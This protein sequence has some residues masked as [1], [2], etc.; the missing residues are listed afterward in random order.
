LTPYLFT[1]LYGLNHGVFGYRR[2]HTELQMEDGLKIN[3]KKVY[4]LYRDLGLCSIIRKKKRKNVNQ[5]KQKEPERIAPNLLDRDFT[6]S[7]LNEKWIT[8]ITEFNILD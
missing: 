7:K 4:R 2:I 6:A 8:D 1:Q 3:H 5:Y